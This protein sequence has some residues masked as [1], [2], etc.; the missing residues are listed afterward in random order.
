MR[1]DDI[2]GGSAILLMAL[3]VWGCSGSQGGGPTNHPD[4][5][6]EGGATG[7]EGVDAGGSPVLRMRT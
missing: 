6:A 7:C 3:F 1:C 4:S 2:G 5:G